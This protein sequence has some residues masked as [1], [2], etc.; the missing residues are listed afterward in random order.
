MSLISM[1]SDRETPTPRTA[2]TAVVSWAT[3]TAIHIARRRSTG[4]R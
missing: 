2:W 4:H 3:I 1:S